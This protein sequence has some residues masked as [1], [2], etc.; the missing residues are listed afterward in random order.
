MPNNLPDPVTVEQMYLAAIL[1]ELKAV[2]ILLDQ[3]PTFS[4]SRAAAETVELREPVKK[5][6]RKK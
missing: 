5:E 6:V 3:P 1:D 4:S 2:R